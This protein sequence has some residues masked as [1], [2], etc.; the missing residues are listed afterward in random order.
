MNKFKHT[1]LLLFIAFAASAQ[2]ITDPVEYNDYFVNNQNK[3]GDELLKLIGMFDNLPEDKAIVNAQLNKVIAECDNAIAAVKSIKPI[4][5]EFNLRNASMDLFV[6]YKSTM[7]NDYPLMIDELYKPAPDME[8][9]NAVLLKVQD[10]EA[11]V[12]KKFQEA[13]QQFATFHNIKLEE[14]EL[15]GEFDGEEE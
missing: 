10:G 12:D 5:N 4:A 11:I 2:T 13:Q 6:F 14:N 7:S 15:Q 8:K 1:L 9:L 3:I